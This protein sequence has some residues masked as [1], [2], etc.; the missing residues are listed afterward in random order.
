MAFFWP[1]LAECKSKDGAA[2]D[3]L[4][5]RISAATTL[6]A[7]RENCVAQFMQVARRY[8]REN[9]SS[10]RRAGARGDTLLVACFGGGASIAGCAGLGTGAA[11]TGSVGPGAASMT[12]FTAPSATGATGAT[13]LAGCSRVV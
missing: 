3:W 9:R 5:S 13:A 1:P 11:L 4:R 10:G 2:L 8:L 7:P 6:F 12:P